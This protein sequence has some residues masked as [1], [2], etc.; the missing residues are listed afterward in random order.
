MKVSLN[1]VNKFTD[2]KLP[3]NELVEK[4][5][6]QLGAVDEVIDIGKKYEGIMVAKVVQCV[7]HPNADKLSLCLIDDGKADKKVKRDKNGLIQVVCGAPNVK[8]GQ[9][10]V[11]LPPGS[12]VPA[13]ASKDPFVLEAR[14]LRGLVS[15]G[16]IA[17]AKELDLGDD[18]SGILVLDD[19]LKLGTSFAE[20]Y[21]LDDFI[22]DIENKMFTHRPDLFGM[23]GIARE[24]AGIQ[25]K[26]FKSP[27]WYRE[28]SNLSNDGRKNV[29]DLSV[30]NDVTNLVPRFSAVA[31]KD[32]KVQGSPIWL[33]TYLARAG[34]RPIN[35]IV[36]ITN[37]YM[38]ETA[39]PLHAYDYDKV[40]TG[41]LGVREAKEGEQ[42]RAIGG[43]VIKLKKGAIVIT[44]GQKAIGLGG[45]MGGADTEVDT[46]TKNIILEVATFDMN[47]TRR[48]AMEHGL[49]T[50]AATRFTKNQ[51][52]R[53]NR[54]VLVK[55]LDDIKKLAGGR[56]ASK[57]VDIKS[58]Q[59]SSKT[60]TL[61]AAFVNSR[62]GTD[63]PV[64]TMKKLLENVEFE[65]SLAHAHL[66]IR[67]PFWRTDIEIAEDIVEEVGR[68]YGYDNIT[69]K[70]PKRS[71]KP[72][73]FNEMF[74]LKSKIRQALVGAGANE[75]LTYSFLNGLLIKKANQKTEDAYHLRNALSPD[76]QY[77][78]LS[79]TPSLLEKVHPNIKLGFEEFAIFE[80]NKSHNKNQK[81]EAEPNLPKEIE[82]LA[83]VVA[84]RDKS[85]KNSGAAY[86]E[87]K[88]YLD[89]L[90]S[91]LG[92]KLSYLAIEKQ[93]NYPF[94]KP[95]EAARSA[96]VSDVASGKLLGIVGQY[97]QNT[98]QDLKLPNY[99]A[100]FEI[101]LEYLALVAKPNKSYHLLNRYP[102]VGQDIC[103]RV[104]ASLGY[105][106]LTDFI[107][108]VLKS[109]SRQ[110]DYEFLITPIDTFQ[111]QGDDEHKQT[112]WHIE[113]QHP[114]RT[115]TNE[116]VNKLFAK[117][118]EQAKSKFNAERI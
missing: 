71:I 35:N 89:Y 93:P 65:V 36:D 48:T 19:N 67:A 80:M 105:Q 107:S 15:N 2:V 84:G 78:R 74:R 98:I 41:V 11:W 13:T 82:T 96:L 75:V 18:H 109:Q 83:L 72:I 47:L 110:H 88:T 115:L 26:S 38:L 33:R 59:S 50:D 70:L 94:V 62:L 31:I 22:I 101:G 85:H 113:L 69:L 117:I 100:G 63:L 56:V 53:Q 77:Y 42:V 3:V 46:A 14:E 39:Q 51:S 9:L 25:G 60:I 58:S 55:A 6:A 40:K 23:L 30:K 87:A 8:A 90:A 66:V 27:P 37:Y 106:T 103:L 57:I 108:S 92:I 64:A 79:L 91:K 81:D 114:E 97:K 17:S 29:L 118:A 24:I 61:D 86:Y 5:G 52:P 1:W 7:K 21:Q 32:V 95:F 12:V 102:S 54:A 20:A 4:I 44:D 34:I 73:E 112:T 49:F 10:V 111:K 104:K 68:L 116:E 28:D 43:K 99:S 45:V 76:L 16:M